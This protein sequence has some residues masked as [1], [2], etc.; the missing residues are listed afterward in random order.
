MQI[1]SIELENGTALGLKID[2]EHAPLLVIRA[3]RGFVMCGYLD[4]SMAERLDDVA[5]KVTGVRSF[6][7]V[8]ASCVVEATQAAADLGITVG[9]PAR[10]ALER[11]F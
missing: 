8:L 5:V 7:D 10:Q 1:E 3:P 6:K 4:I 2:M 9:M 11:M